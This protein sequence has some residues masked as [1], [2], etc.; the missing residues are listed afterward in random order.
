MGAGRFARGL[1]R[2]A[3]HRAGVENVRTVVEASVEAG[4]R[5]LTLYAFST[6]NWN[7]P[8]EEVRGPSRP[9]RPLPRA[10]AEYSGP[11]RCAPAPPGQSGRPGAG[12]PPARRA[13]HATHADNTR[14]H[15]N[16][17][18]NYGGRAEI[19]RAAR[20]LVRSNLTP[21]QVTEAQWQPVWTLP[22]S[23]ISTW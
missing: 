12:H 7:R 13:G 4:V 3:G 21:D 19:V 23:L 9:D 14:L 11:K 15:L 10:R 5:H 2:S 1:P 18:F 6:E 22:V 8:A 16:M 20:R 17:A